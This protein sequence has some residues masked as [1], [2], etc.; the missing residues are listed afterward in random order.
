MRGLLGLIVLVLDIL[1]II[2]IIKGRTKDT[3]KILWV[4]LII[5]LPVIG[6]LLWWFMGRKK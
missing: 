4:V 1:A 5:F 3:E 6:L 2:E